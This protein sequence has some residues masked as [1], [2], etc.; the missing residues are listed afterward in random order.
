MESTIE[1]VD[2]SRQSAECDETP[3]LSELWQ[4]FYG[5]LVEYADTRL[6][7]TP[8]TAFDGEDVA[9]SAFDSVYRGLADGRYVDFR[10]PD[11]LWKLLF[12]IARSKLVDRVRAERRLKRGEGRV[13]SESSLLPVDDASATRVLEQFPDERPTHDVLVDVDEQFR[14]LLSLLDDQMLREI[15]LLRLAGYTQLEIAEVFD[16]TDRT[17]KRKLQ[18]IR[19]IWN[20]TV[21]GESDEGFEIR[22]PR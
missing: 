5:R 8:V 19:R 6:E 1:S 9:L 14:H 4:R 17:I 7:Q 22:N 3:E 15:A 10:S 2:V 12:R 20:A 11:D 21:S 13:R 16:L 18:S